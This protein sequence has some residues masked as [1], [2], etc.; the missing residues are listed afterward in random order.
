LFTKSSAAGARPPLPPLPPP[1]PPRPLPPPPPP[2]PPA[3][4]RVLIVRNCK[5]N[6]SQCSEQTLVLRN[7]INKIPKTNNALLAMHFVIKSWSRRSDPLVYKLI[8]QL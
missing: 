1:P 3:W 8:T 2:P 6:K 7:I 4:S 5:N